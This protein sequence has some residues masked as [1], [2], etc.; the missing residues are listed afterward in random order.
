MAVVLVALTALCAKTCRC[1]QVTVEAQPIVRTSDLVR[2]VYA[3]APAGD[4]EHLY[5]SEQNAMRI[6]KV[7]LKSGALSV[8]LDLPDIEGTQTGLQTFAFHPDYATSG[9]VYLNLYDP[10]DRHVKVLEFTRSASDPNVL[11]PDS[12]R[13]VYSL[14]NE[15]GSH[16]GGW[17]GFGP[18]D[19]LYILTGDGGFLGRP[20]DG[21]AAQDLT[22]HKGKL[23]RIDVDGDDFPEDAAR[24]YAIPPDNPFLGEDGADGEDEIFAYGFR[25]AFR[26]GFD[27]LTGDL[28]IGDV[29]RTAREEI[30]FIPAGSAGGQNFGWRA[31]EGTLDSLYPDPIPPD[32]IDPI[33]E[34]PRA[35]GAAVIGGYVY[36]GDDFPAMQGTYFFAD[37][38]RDEA[39]SLRFDGAKVS[40]VA[41]RTQEFAG[42][43]GINFE[44][45][46]LTAITEGGD[47]EL[48][49]LYSSRG[50]GPA[51]SEINPV[52]IYR[53]AATGLVGDY[54]GNGFV[55]QADLDLVLLNWG[56]DASVPPSGW[57]HDLPTETVSQRELDRVLLNWGAVNPGAVGVAAVPE[58]CSHLLAF[59]AA[60]LAA[61]RSLSRRPL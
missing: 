54:N 25:H 61:M 31:K 41:D 6:Q 19:Y 12:G 39:Y 42:S 17:L 8:F 29:G 28:Y 45:F 3:T 32:A 7:D 26:A 58:P 46:G 37:F 43:G 44:G 59:G 9:R 21:I 30:D 53:I 27:R 57:V 48:Y 51:Y 2:A 5:V 49:F 40:D 1:Q 47:G 13:T 20:D 50:P 15:F 35:S 55:E 52:E 56:A 36:R 38:I 60:M 24:N 4:S 23:L 18:D 22:D 33:Y 14:F 10:S 16:N 11:D 34:Y